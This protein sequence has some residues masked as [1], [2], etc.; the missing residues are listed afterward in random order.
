MAD[1][2]GANATFIITIPTIFSIPQTL[3]GFAADDV[4]GTEPLDSVET[5]IGVDGLLSAG[6]VFKEVK[7][8]INL[9]ADSPSNQIFDVWWAQ[10]QAQRATFVAQGVVIL[11]ALKTKWVLVNG[12]LTRYQPIPTVKKLVDPKRF[13]ITWES[14][15][16]AVSS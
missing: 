8:G 3:Q 1:I 2:T 7:L 16:P 15:S 12:F 13:E 4:F 5:R 6:F 9:Q 11:P 10:M 14:I